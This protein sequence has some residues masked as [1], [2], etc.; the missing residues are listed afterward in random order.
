MPTLSGEPSATVPVIAFGP[1]FQTSRLSRRRR[2][3]SATHTCSP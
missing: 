1:E 2:W 3:A